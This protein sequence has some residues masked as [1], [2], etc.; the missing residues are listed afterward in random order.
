MKKLW[1]LLTILLLSIDAKFNFPVFKGSNLSPDTDFTVLERTSEYI[2]IG[3]NLVT[4][5]LFWS[6]VGLGTPAQNFSLILDT[7]KEYYS[8]SFLNH[9]RIFWIACGKSRLHSRLPYQPRYLVQSSY[10]FNISKSWMFWLL[11][12]L[13]VRFA[14][15]FCCLTKSFVLC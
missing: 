12:M 13:V 6:T 15:L 8:L 10:K 11:K 5:G 2:N 7:G 1:I 3:G 4:K 9:R 14:S